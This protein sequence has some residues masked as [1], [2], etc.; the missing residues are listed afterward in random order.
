MNIR[1]SRL[2]FLLIFL[3]S[4]SDVTLRVFGSD[5]VSDTVKLPAFRVEGSFSE[6]LCAARFRYHVPGN[7]L[8]EL[9]LRKVPKKW[10]VAGIEVGD[11]I[12]AID[13]RPIDGQKLS[14]LSIYLESK[15][16]DSDPDPIVF[17]FDIRSREKKSVYR[18][19]VA[20]HKDKDGFTIVFP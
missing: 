8:K 14:D 10:L 7:G 11:A 16:K 20:L 12:V 9:V 19:E 4:E 18:I 1:S 5:V 6:L 13:G 3:L 15:S 2:L 17:Q